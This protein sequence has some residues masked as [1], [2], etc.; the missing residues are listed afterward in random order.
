MGHA[1]GSKPRPYMLQG[2]LTSKSSKILT[3]NE[4][5][6]EERAKMG[7]YG[8]KNGLS[9]AAKH[10]SLL[11]D[12]KLTCSLCC[13]GYII[14]GWGLNYQ[15]KKYG[16]LAEIAKFNACQLPAIRYL[17]RV[18]YFGHTHSIVFY[19]KQECQSTNGMYALDSRQSCFITGKPVDR[20]QILWKG[21]FHTETEKY[22]NYVARVSL[23]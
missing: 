5:I 12:G 14:F 21:S 9:K 11:S 10:F 8:T 7:R 20:L 17:V 16:I 15:I 19:Q 1:A 6:L 23:H 4:C 2:S 18:L 3:Y 22:S 13:S